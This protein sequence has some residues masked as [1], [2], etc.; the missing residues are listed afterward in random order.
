MQKIYRVGGFYA[1]GIYHS[2]L[3]GATSAQQAIDS[4]LAADSRLIRITKATIAQDI[5]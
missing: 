4:V 2:H 3:V 1:S 5:K